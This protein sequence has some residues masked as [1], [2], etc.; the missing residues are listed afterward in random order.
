[1]L[2]ANTPALADEIQKFFA[3]NPLSGAAPKRNFSATPRWI[4]THTLL[5]FSF[6]WAILRLHLSTMPKLFKTPAR[7]IMQMKWNY[8]GW[9]ERKKERCRRAESEKIKGLTFYFNRQVGDFIMKRARI[10]RTGPFA[11]TRLVSFT[12]ALC[13]GSKES[14]A[15]RTHWMQPATRPIHVKRQTFS[16]KRKKN[17][18]YTF[19]K[20]KMKEMNV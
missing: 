13:F 11:L 4:Y 5:C 17:T 1:M 14:R 18:E 7:I 12:C 15:K 10:Q 2:R 20:G 6:L 9:K 3:L 19:C 16:Q 8:A